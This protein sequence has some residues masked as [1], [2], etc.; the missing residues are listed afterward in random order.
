M[1]NIAMKIFD[2]TTIARIILIAVIVLGSIAVYITN[3]VKFLIKS[4]NYA[5][6][7][8]KNIKK[9]REYKNRMRH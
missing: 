3:T 1:S 4:Y 5:M 9:R 8:S 6:L 2:D 7:E